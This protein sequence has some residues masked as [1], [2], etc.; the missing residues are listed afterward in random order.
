MTYDKI[1]L[2]ETI[3]MLVMKMKALKRITR[4]LIAILLTLFIIITPLMFSGCNSSS[5]IF[6]NPE[7]M[8]ANAK[9]LYQK[10]N[11]SS[12]IYQLQIYCEEKPFNTE[13]Y[14]LLGDWYM[15]MGDEEKSNHNYRMVSVNLGCESNQLSEAD[16]ITALTQGS[17]DFTLKIYPNVKYTKNMTLSFSGENITPENSVNGSINGTTNLLKEDQN[18]LTTEWFNIDSSKKYILLTGNFNCSIWQFADR[19]DRI[20]FYRDKGEFR[21]LT[22]V[23]FDNKAYSSVE[24]P[25]DAVKA[26][27]TYY[28]ASIE[29]TVISDDDIFITYGKSMSGYTGKETQTYDIP[30]LSENQ[31][32][33]YK[34]EKWELFDGE[35]Y[36]PLDWE[37]IKAVKGNFC[38]VSGDLCGVVEITYNDSQNSS[39][40]VNKYLQYGVKFDTRTGVSVGQRLDASRGLNFNYTIENQWVEQGENDFDNAYPWCEM[41]LCNVT[42]DNKGNKTVV[43]KGDSEYSETGSNGNVMV[44]IPKFYSKRV[45]T[46]DYEE[47]WIS[48]KK[49]SGYKLDPIF[50]G[51]NGKELDY[52]YVGAYLGSEADNKIVSVKDK[53]PTLAL[54]YK[55]TLKMA[56]NNGDGFSEMNYSMCSALQRLFVVETGTLDSSSLFRGYNSKYYYYETSNITNSGLATVD[57]EKTNTITVYNNYNTRKIALGSSIVIFEGWNSY[58]NS[59]GKQREVTDIKEVDDYLEI[60]FNGKPLDIKKAKTAI[61]N[62]PDKTGKTAELDYCTAVFDAELG[63]A[64]FKYRN[65]ENLYGSA[66][67][68]LDDDAYIQDGVFY[69][70]NEKGETKSVKAKIAEQPADLGSN[71][72]VNT[73]CCIKKTTYDKDNPFIMLPSKVGDGASLH[74]YYGDFWRYEK[75]DSKKYLIFG[76][77]DNNF[78]ATG[79]FNLQAVIGD[80]DADLSRCSARIMYR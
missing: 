32:I 34:N 53:Y 46:D 49:H 8:I 37:E 55:N 62:I 73:Y 58:K 52:V 50:K 44:Q 42:F 68:M 77:E 41:K 28:D 40:D 21:N 13:A 38:S 2:I 5:V 79:M 45:V 75:N 23:D 72:Y 43:Y 12:A 47:I 1:K 71:D 19:E 33:T 26:R 14:M 36:K 35:I 25:D 9:A 6:N 27:V 76:G 16:R 65:I 59:S 63:K 29:N 31:Y 11:T 39:T 48:G 54:S 60:T 70:E 20:K 17:D 80:S 66:S 56:K 24:I 22:E 51:Y 10:G 74:N 30:D 67:I 18:C 61:S 7:K 3:L 4:P 69:F 15:Q 57:A 64:S 78:K